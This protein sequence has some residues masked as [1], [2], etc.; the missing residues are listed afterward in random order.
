[1]L[2]TWNDRVE[3]EIQQLTEEI[4]TISTKEL[5][6]KKIRA[7]NCLSKAAR[8]HIH[9]YLEHWRQYNEVIN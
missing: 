4:K 9:S 5:Q 6:V 1:M 3:P 8:K 7:M 2:E